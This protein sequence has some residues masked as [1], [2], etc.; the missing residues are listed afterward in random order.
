M[1][2]KEFEDF[3]KDLDPNEEPKAAPEREEDDLV[4]SSFFEDATSSAKKKTEVKPENSF[5][6]F[7]DDIFAPPPPD[8]EEQ[9]A[10]YRKVIEAMAPKRVVIRTMDIGAEKTPSY[11]RMDQEANPALGLRGI[12]L[13]FAKPALFKTQLRAILRAGAGTES[14]AVMFPMVIAASEVRKCREIIRQCADELESEHKA[15]GIPEIGVMIETPAAALTAEELAEEDEELL[16][17]S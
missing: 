5:S 16:L 14:A 4:F 1:N 3:F 9:Y 13:C 7:D 8:E 11:L 2:S 10:A 6:E 15:Y 17:S 12:R